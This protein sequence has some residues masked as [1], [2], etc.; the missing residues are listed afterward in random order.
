MSALSSEKLEKF[1]YVTVEDVN[2][3]RFNKP[4]LNILHWV[5]VD[6]MKKKRRR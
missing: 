2:Q 3:E 5:R 6:E 1:E 4:K